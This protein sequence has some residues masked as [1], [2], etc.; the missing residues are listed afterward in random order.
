MRQRPQSDVRGG[1]NVDIMGSVCRCKF[2]PL[3]FLG[4]AHTNNFKE[5]NKKYNQDTLPVQSGIKI[6][7]FNRQTSTAQENE[8]SLTP[9]LVHSVACKITSQLV[10]KMVLTS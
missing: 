1:M 4:G 6:C 7:S 3:F 8:D 5:V 2:E 10:L 9:H